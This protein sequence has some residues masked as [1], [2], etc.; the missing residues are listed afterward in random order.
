MLPRKLSL[1]T[2]SHILYVLP[3]KLSL[4][5]SQVQVILVFYMLPGKLSLSMHILYAS[6]E[7]ESVLKTALLPLS[8]LSLTLSFSHSLSLSF[9]FILSLC[10]GFYLDLYVTGIP[11]KTAMAA[12]IPA[13]C[14]KNP[15]KIGINKT[16]NLTIHV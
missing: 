9:P 7:V 2:G 1:S 5:I 6:R 11:A 16:R 13:T 4:C 15:N 3:R 12:R 8:P 14:R 10:Y